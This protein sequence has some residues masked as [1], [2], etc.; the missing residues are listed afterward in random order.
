MDF[1]LDGR[2]LNS[3]LCESLDCSE[4]AKENVESIDDNVC[5]KQYI[6]MTIFKNTIA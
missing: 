1:N 2:L 5:E 4:D 6:E 3:H